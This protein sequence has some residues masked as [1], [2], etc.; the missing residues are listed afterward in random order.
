MKKFIILTILL[1]MFLLP[2]GTVC[3]AVE[4]VPTEPT[5]SV[6]DYFVEVTKAQ[7]FHESG[8]IYIAT[9]Y[10]FNPEAVYNYT[11]EGEEQTIDFNRIILVLKQIYEKQKIEYI[12]NDNTPNNI[13]KIDKVYSSRTE[14]NHEQGITGDEIYEPLEKLSEDFWFTTYINKSPSYLANGGKETLQKNYHDLGLILFGIDTVDMNLFKFNYCYGTDYKSITTNGRMI[15]MDNMYYHIFEN[16]NEKSEI[17]LYQ[18]V[19]NSA[20]WYGVIIGSSLG[21]ILLGLLGY[22]VF[23]KRR[24]NG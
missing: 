23:R 5:T 24:K 4:P 6:D 11:V 20:N 8:R 10:Y 3:Y 7:V 21:V 18:K 22:V 19:Q 1:V 12:Y 16:I 17:I 2:F 14:L 13:I 15:K 9:Q